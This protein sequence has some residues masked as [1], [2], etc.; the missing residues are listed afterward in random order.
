MNSEKDWKQLRKL[1]EEALQ[2]TNFA[3]ARIIL[4]G[5]RVRGNSDQYSD[6][7]VLVVIDRPLKFN[8]KINIL[9]EIYHKLRGF[10]YAVDIILKTNQE[11]E[12]EKEMVGTL[13][14]SLVREKGEIYENNHG[15]K[16]WIEKAHNDLK[17][18]LDELN[19][20]SP[21]LDMVCF[22]LQQFVEKYMKAFL[23]IKGI[24]QP[25]THDLRRLLD[26][27]IKIDSKFELFYDSTLILL[28]PCGVETRYPSD[29]Y[30]PEKEFIDKAV[31]DV[32]KFKAFMENEFQK[33]GN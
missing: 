33:I 27:C 18:A 7:D 31:V 5:S 26:M 13:I 1:I 24:S 6:F 2:K 8:D 29:F 4:F 14:N 23:I 16:K 21:V 22:H 20:Q 32:Q 10:P 15:S 12:I 17:I 19:T 3:G 11:Y 9:G 30:Y 28:T 25:R